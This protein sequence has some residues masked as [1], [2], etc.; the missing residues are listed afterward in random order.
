[1]LAV[2]VPLT[3]SMNDI[4]GLSASMHPP[5]FAVTVNC[6]AGR[7]SIITGPKRKDSLQLPTLLL[8][9]QNCCSPATALLKSTTKPSS[10]LLGV[11]A[12]RTTQHCQW[13]ERCIILALTVINE[14]RLNCN[15]R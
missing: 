15:Y 13:P 5:G 11:R 14:H 8:T 10:G 6:R 1:M 12:N 4:T 2:Y 7:Y 9:N 3:V